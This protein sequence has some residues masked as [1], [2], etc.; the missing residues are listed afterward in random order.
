MNNFKAITCGRRPTL[1]IYKFFLITSFGQTLRICVFVARISFE[2]NSND[3]IFISLKNRGA[4]SQTPHSLF[5][6]LNLLMNVLSNVRIGLMKYE[7]NN[8]RKKIV[9]YKLCKGYFFIKCV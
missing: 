6:N 1:L 9:M 8:E 4:C 2:K 5:R 3:K 7:K